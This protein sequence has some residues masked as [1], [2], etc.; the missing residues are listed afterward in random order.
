MSEKSEQ[1][2]QPTRRSVL[3]SG[4]GLTKRYGHRQV[5]AGVDITIFAGETLAVVGQ[6]GAGK[7]TLLY[8][9]SGV[10][11]P[12]EGQVVIAGSR[13][14]QLDEA[15][16][17][18]LRRNTFGCVTQTGLLVAE[19]TV[20]DNVARPLLLAGYGRR[21][22]IAQAQDWLGRLGL[23]GLRRRS[24][25]AL[26]SAESQRVAIA[27]ALARHP[28]VLFADEP[29]GALGRHGGAETMT[30]LLRAATEVGAATVVMTRDQTL[31]SRCERVIG[32]RDG[33]VV[34]GVM[35]T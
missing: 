12:D 26:S 31:A 13:I 16:R 4:S 18:R 7:T 20:E 24:P 17:A 3:V 25:A 29:T 9:L 35:T 27:R 5:L 2:G 33:R 19:L 6:S 21:D 1:P 23:E 14:D 22:A 34:G 10:M 32:L 28:K 8:L 15:K 11:P 30:A